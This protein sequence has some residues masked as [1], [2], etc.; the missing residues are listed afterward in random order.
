MDQDFRSPGVSGTVPI[1]MMCNSPTSSA[2]AAGS[3]YI[4][5]SA[6]AATRLPVSRGAHLWA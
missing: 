3:R 4:G 1:D 6:Q 2:F 5:K